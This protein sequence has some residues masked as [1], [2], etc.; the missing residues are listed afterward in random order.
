MLLYRIDYP[1]LVFPL[2][3]THETVATRHLILRDQKCLLSAVFLPQIEG[4]Q[5]GLSKLEVLVMSKVE[6]NQQRT[7][8][9]SRDVLRLNSASEYQ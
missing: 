9:V 2:P 7:G 1:T 3:D 5:G 4:D 6:L 8:C